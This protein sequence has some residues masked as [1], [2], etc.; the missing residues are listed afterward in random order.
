M[1]Y[2]TSCVINEE[3]VKG[4]GGMRGDGP[5]EWVVLK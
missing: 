3:I 2:V 1:D 4:V 5:K